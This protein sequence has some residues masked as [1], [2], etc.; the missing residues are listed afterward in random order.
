MV[1]L[2]YQVFGAKMDSSI[3]VEFHAI[4]LLILYHLNVQSQDFGEVKV[5]KLN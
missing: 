1:Y 4:G 3:L 2:S 5:I